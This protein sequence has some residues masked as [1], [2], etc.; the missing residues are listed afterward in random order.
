METLA[1]SVISL[2]APY[3]AKGAEEFAKTAGKVAFEQCEPLVGRLRRWW[4]GDPDAAA[5]ADN[6]AKDPQKY[7]TLLG[8]LLSTDLTK[9]PAFAAELRS[10]VE[11]MG[12]NIEVIQNM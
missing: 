7:G 10:L 8:Q 9:D 4:S 1:A 3:L 5:A 2:V 6:L 11:G 12:P